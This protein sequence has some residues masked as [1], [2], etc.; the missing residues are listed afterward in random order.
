[1]LDKIKAMI[2]FEKFDDAKILIDTDNKLVY[3]IT[4]KYLF[5]GL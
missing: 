5:S 2:G 4:L 1:M 3:E